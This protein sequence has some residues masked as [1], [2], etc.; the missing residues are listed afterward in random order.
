MR[1]LLIFASPK[2]YADSTLVKA[3]ASGQN[4]SPSERTVE[5][6]QE[7]AMPRFPYDRDSYCKSESPEWT[8]QGT[9]Y[10]FQD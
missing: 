2:V 5:E 4:L 8:T 6:F 7:Q 1:A 3:D 10:W 9:D